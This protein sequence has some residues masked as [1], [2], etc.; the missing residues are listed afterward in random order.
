MSQNAYFV[1][2]MLHVRIILEIQNHLYQMCILTDMSL[3][4]IVKFKYRK[5]FT[6]HVF[7]Y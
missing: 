6:I 2:K 3:H 1:N 4:I 5:L 7:R